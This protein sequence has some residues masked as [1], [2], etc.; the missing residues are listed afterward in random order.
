[1]DVL[2]I[3]EETEFRT[4]EAESGDR[5]I[6]VLEIHQ[7]SIAL[8]FTDVQMPSSRG[9]FALAREASS[10]GPHISIVVASGHTSLA[11][12]N[13]LG[14]DRQSALTLLHCLRA[15]RS[16]EHAQEQFVC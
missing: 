6:A 10:R 3:L 2:D 13:E 15:H 5:A 8:L 7:A 14:R 1:M 9:G 16:P 11:G 4:M 12:G